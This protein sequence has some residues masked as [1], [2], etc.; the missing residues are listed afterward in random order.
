LVFK[1]KYAV[2][3][4]GRVFVNVVDV[5]ELKQVF[6]QYVKNLTVIMDV[7]ELRK[8]DIEF[9]KQ[10]FTK[11]DGAKK[12]TFS[13]KNPGDNSQMTLVSTKC[14]F[15]INGNMLESMIHEH[16]YQFYLN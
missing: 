8:E 2:L 3:A 5:S 15:T 14:N 6:E 10:N 7:N 4:D 1:I 16:S 9:F 12:L 13:F 11:G